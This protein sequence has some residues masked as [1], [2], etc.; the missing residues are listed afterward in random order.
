[1]MRIVLTNAGCIIN[2][3]SLLGLKGGKGSVGYAASKAGVIG[4]P[5]SIQ[6]H[7]YYRGLINH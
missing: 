6:L 7:P 5:P 4:R 2:I 1:M 3:S